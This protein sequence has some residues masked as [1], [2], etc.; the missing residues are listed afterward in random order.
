MQ[1]FVHVF[2]ILYLKIYKTGLT[3]MALTHALVLDNNRTN[4][5]R[6][7][8]NGD[9]KPKIGLYIGSWN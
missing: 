3:L 6:A 8:H 2:I 5:G 7:E 9:K 4:L 1:A